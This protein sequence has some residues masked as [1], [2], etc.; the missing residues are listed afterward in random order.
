MLY[1]P[2]KMIQKILKKNNY[3]SLKKRVGLIFFLICMLLYGQNTVPSHRSDLQESFHS[4]LQVIQEPPN[5]IE[6]VVH[7]QQLN[8]GRSI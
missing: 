3:Y 1:K 5:D 8:C 4:F 7:F 2:F 6:N